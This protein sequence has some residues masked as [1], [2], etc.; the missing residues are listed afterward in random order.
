MLSNTENMYFAQVGPGTPAGNLLRHYWHPIALMKELEE[1]NPFPLMVMGEELALFRSKS[2]EIGLVADRCAHRGASLSKGDPSLRTTRIDERGIRCCYH[3]W[4]Y[5]T[6]GQCLE[7]PAEPALGENYCKKIKLV[8]YPVEEKYGFI[9]AFMGEGEPPL[10]PAYDV[11][12]NDVPFRMQTRAVRNFNYFQFMENLADPTHAAVLHEDTPLEFKLGEMPDVSFE[13]TEHGLRIIA[14]REEFDR[15]SEIVF[16]TAGRFVV[17]FPDLNVDALFWV[18]PVHDTLTH[19]LHTL[20]PQGITP[21]NKQDKLKQLRS[22]LFKSEEDRINHS[23]RIGDQDEFAMGSQ[24][25]IAHRETEHLGQS[26]RAIVEFRKLFREAID[27]AANGEVP[28]GVIKGPA[29]ST[30]E[31]PLVQ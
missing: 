9:W 21:E 2:G 7:M 14:V 27:D 31:F 12:A 30:I 8:S 22:Y 28:L 3:G 23:T 26:D 15:R 18:L 17:P 11:L 5:G 24:G 10:I 6:D 29:N 1:R 20:V 25:P 13:R 19:T 4:L 16:P